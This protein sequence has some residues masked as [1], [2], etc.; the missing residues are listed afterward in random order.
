M[1]E[2]MKLIYV[3]NNNNNLNTNIM[4]TINNS[5]NLEIILKIII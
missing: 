3:N 1:H 5:Y 2:K 4:L